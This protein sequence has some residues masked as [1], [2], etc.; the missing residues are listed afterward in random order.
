MKWLSVSG[1]GRQWKSSLTHLNGRDNA[2][3]E[4]EEL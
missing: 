1:I 3:N 4:L 2:G